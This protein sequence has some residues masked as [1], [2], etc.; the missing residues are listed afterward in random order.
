MKNGWGG[1]GRGENDKSCFVFA[2]FPGGEFEFL[3]YKL[4]V[5]HDNTI[6]TNCAQL[7]CKLDPSC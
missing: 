4:M 2:N 3:F 7:M 6:S 5:V 1:F